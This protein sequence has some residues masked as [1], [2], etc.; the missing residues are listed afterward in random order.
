MAR[1]PPFAEVGRSNEEATCRLGLPRRHWVDPDVARA[2]LLQLP[3]LF[4]I[5]RNGC[6]ASAETTVRLPRNRCTTSSEIAV[7]PTPKWLFVFP[8]DTHQWAWGPNGPGPF[9]LVSIGANSQPAFGLYGWAADANT[10]TPQAIQVLTLV[11]GQ[12]SR[13][14]GFVRPDLFTVFGL[15]LRLPAWPDAAAQQ[16]YPP[17]MRPRR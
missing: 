15:P 1:R 16:R 10:F 8:R 4:G 7:R 11:R 3:G 5:N 6:S 12:I 17:A 14:H 9:R 13:V 2:N